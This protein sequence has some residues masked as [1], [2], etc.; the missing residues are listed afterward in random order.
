MKINYVIATYAGVGKRKHKYPL[1]KNVLKEHLSKILFLENNISQ[2]TVMK[3]HCSGKKIKGY[4][5]IEDIISKSSIP[6]K[7]IEC[8]NFGYSNGQWLKA[9][10]IYKD[11]FDYYIFVEDDYCPNINFFDKILI[12]CYKIQFPNN[13]GLLCSLVEGSKKYKTKG[14]Y[15]IH[16]E[17][18]I[19]LNK[20]TLDKLYSF[21]RWR[22]EPRKYLDLID[23]KNDPGFN[24]KR[25]RKSYLG[26]YYQLTLSRL[27]TLSNIEHNDYLD[28]Y[29]DKELNISN[30]KT[31]ENNLLCFPY[32]ADGGTSVGGKIW[33]YVKG[34]KIDKNVTLNKIINSP[35]VPIQIKD[36]IGI[37]INTK[38]F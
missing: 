36:N 9:Y 22:G 14:G 28:L 3:A 6:I 37:K 26:G 35:I 21:P 13:I 32:W 7:V 38:I 15:P 17:G 12:D 18:G 2:I 33:F 8:K 20:E 16:Y 30:K 34:D 11:T 24:W 25:Q 5:D 23:T 1:V 29:I 10:E 19:F 31:N 4:Y 27:F